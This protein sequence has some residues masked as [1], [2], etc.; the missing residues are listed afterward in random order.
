LSQQGTQAP[1]AQTRAIALNGRITQ[2]DMKNNVAAIS[3]GTAAG[4]RA[5]MKFHVTR[6]DRFV[7]DILIFDVDAEKAIGTL[8]LVQVEPQTGDLVTTNL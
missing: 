7:C 5:D 4:V 1:Q 8:D 2:I 3:I 6:G